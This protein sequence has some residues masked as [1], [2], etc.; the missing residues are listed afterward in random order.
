[1]PG[2]WRVLNMPVKQTTLDL[3]GFVI[4]EDVDKLQLEIRMKN[5]TILDYL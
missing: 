5:R 4:P 3:H 2:V 1:M